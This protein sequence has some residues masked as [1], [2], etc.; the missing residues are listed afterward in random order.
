MVFICFS[1]LANAEDLSTLTLEQATQLA[2]NHNLQLKSA[3]ARRDVGQTQIKTANARLNPYLMSDNGIAERTYR[4]G[5]EQYIELGGKRKSRVAVATAQS[6]VIEADI[7][8]QMLNLRTDVRR[9]YSHLYNALERKKT[10]QNIVQTTAELLA[11]AKKRQQSGDVAM[12]DVLGAR[13]AFANARNDEQTVAYQAIEA[14]NR[15]S[16]LMNQPLEPNIQLAPPTT[17]A[18][19]NLLLIPQSPKSGQPLQVQVSEAVVNLDALIQQA[20]K[21]RPELQGNLRAQAV[22]QKQLALARANRIPS[23]RLA[24]GPDLVTGLDGVF[25]AFFMMGN[26]EIPVFNRQQDPIQEAL[27]QI[28]QLQL[29]QQSLKNQITY[30]VINAHIA[31]IANKERVKNYET[32]LLPDAEHVVT[33]ARLSFQEEKASILTPINAQ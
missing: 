19:E 12:V 32:E 25:S 14:K 23:L 29:P 11:V 6:Q 27:A 4:L 26:L 15:L 10:Y 16:S 13:I 31:F 8:T 9:A 22:E 28:K 17:F 21:D 2:I 20:M 24:A 5:L 7:R 3:L 18:Q 1:P 33:L 30:E